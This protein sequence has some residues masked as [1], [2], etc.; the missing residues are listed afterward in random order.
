MARSAIRRS[1]WTLLLAASSVA[2]ISGPPGSAGVTVAPTAAPT[3]GASVTSAPGAPSAATVTSTPNAS[4]G[5]SSAAGPPAATLSV[6]GGDPVTGQLGS[7]TWNSSG[8]DSPWLPGSSIAVGD[9]ER[10]TV[11]FADGPAVADWSARRVK[12]GTT[13]GSGTVGL[14]SGGPPP[15]F[16]APPA[17]R[18]SVQVTV[19]FADGIGSASYY[20]AITVR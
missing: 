2:C 17:G 14:G 9:G 12:A 11:A 6:E 5:V 1:A 8:S 13:D 10:L 15:T 4:A 7:Y 20:W 3:P 16:G 19:D 18:W